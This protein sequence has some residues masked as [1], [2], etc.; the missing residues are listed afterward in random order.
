[1][2]N[3]LSEKIDY[4]TLFGDSDRFA[5]GLFTLVAYRNGGHDICFCSSADYMMIFCLQGSV[6]FKMKYGQSNLE[7]G[8]FVVVHRSKIE[9]CS[10]S[11]G[12]VLLKYA[13]MGKLSEYMDKCT[14]AFQ[15]DVLSP[16]RIL[17]SLAAWLNTFIRQMIRDSDNASHSYAMQRRELVRLLLAYPQKELEEIFAPLFAC[18]RQCEVTGVCIVHDDEPAEKSKPESHGRT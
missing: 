1:M 12:T 5:G 3:L 7:A 17:P 9:N 16:L 11:S 15:T 14:A 18:S 6:L 4:L 13:T 2:T 10:C 8:Q